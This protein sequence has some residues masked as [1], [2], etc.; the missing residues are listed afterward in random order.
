M[1]LVASAIVRNE[2]GR[3]LE[4]WIGHLREFVDEVVVLDD[5]SEDVTAP[6]LKAWGARVL[7]SAEARFDAHEGAARQRLL[8]FTLAQE[9]TH[10]LAIDADE[11]VTDGALLRAALEADARSQ[12]WT[13]EM[14]EVWELDGECL[15]VRVD[16]AWRPHGVP[17]MYRV[18]LGRP[19]AGEAL[20]RIEN[21]PLACGRVPLA[22]SRSPQRTNAGVSLLHFGWANEAA[23]QARYDRY[24]RIDGGRYHRRDHLESILGPWQLA[25][26]PWPERLTRYR[27]AIE[28]ASTR[29]PPAPVS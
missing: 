15:C 8:E 23:R 12:V 7:E 29:R 22:V 21:R 26:R 2:A 28:D 11:F 10:V 6:L 1:K 16:G 17:V 14:E 19:G 20:W 5:A 3:Y 9:P 13:L 25:G 4:P 18:D 24:M 27:A